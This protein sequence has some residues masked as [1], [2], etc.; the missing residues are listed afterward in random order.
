MNSQ[1]QRGSTIGEDY[2]QAI[3]SQGEIAD[4]QS[5]QDNPE[6]WDG[7]PKHAGSSASEA[8]ASSFGQD[9]R[10]SQW[11]RAQA[12]METGE[13]VELTV[14]GFNRGGLLVDWDGLRG[15]VPASHLLDFAP[16]QDEEA[17]LAELE[18]RVGTTLDAK[19]IELEPHEKRFILSQRLTS[20]ETKRRA[21]VFARI[22]PRDV[23]Q[24]RVTNL[25]SFGAFVDL[26][27]V[28][29]L[30]H[31]S[32]MSWGRVDHPRDVLEI[33]Q[34][35]DV[36][37]LNTDPEEGRIG[38]SLKRLLPDPWE[39][40]EDRYDVGQLVEGVITNVVNFGAFTR[41]EEGLEGLIHVSELAEGSFL[42]P[43]NVVQEGEKVVA[44]VLSVDG[45]RRRMALSLRRVTPPEH[46]GSPAEHI[47]SEEEPSDEDL[48]EKTEPVTEDWVPSTAPATIYESHQ[49]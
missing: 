36:Y 45:R 30:V 48:D 35:V 8:D 17:R 15:F 33:G 13:S 12:H 40:V 47:A 24:G 6:L 41:I 22:N 39:T 11:A 14:T 31:I 5:A 28:E 42:H 34:L 19:I 10:D 25:C 1:G 49:F 38:L 37:V 32:E 43:R 23:C 2:W 7:F 29:G 20:D 27:G 44:R 46:E 4:G 16:Y 9:G 18:L 3:L 26:G 21:Q